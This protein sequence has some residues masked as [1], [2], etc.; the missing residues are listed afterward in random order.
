M[1]KFITII[2]AFAILTSVDCKE[3]MN[4]KYITCHLKKTTESL[5]VN[6]HSQ[7][8]K[9]SKTCSCPE[10]K[11]LSLKESSKKIKEPVSLELISHSPLNTCFAIKP[12]SNIYLSLHHTISPHR[13]FSPIKTIQLLI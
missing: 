5:K 12:A 3:F 2:L 8:K 11:N 4:S 9:A 10:K 6:C 7:T 13:L 1:R